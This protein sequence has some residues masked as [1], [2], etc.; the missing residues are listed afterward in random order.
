M[1]LAKL[2]VTKPEAKRVCLD[3]G[4]GKNKREGFIGV[5]SLKFDGVDVVCDLA[6]VKPFYKWKYIRHFEDGIFKPWP[7][8]T[9]SID[10]AH[11]SHFL[12]HL[13]NVERVHFFNELWRVMKNGGTATIITPNWSHA[14]AFGDPTHQWPPASPWWPLYGDR[15]WREGNAPHTGLKCDFV[16]GVAGS[17]DARLNGRNPEFTQ[18]AMNEQTNAWRD[19]IVTLTARK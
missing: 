11:S 10:E 5:D 19:L 17:W 9:N 16:G 13:T 1:K 7:W 14:C 12:E 8:K 15:Q 18:N 3:L 2:K 4:C 6:E